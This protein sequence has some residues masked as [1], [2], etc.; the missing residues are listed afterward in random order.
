MRKLFATMGL[1]GLVAAPALARP[2]TPEIEPNDTKPFATNA[3]GLVNGDT[4]SGNTT[5]SSTVTPGATSADYFRLRTAAGAL[6]IYRNRMIITTTGTAGHTGT[7]RGLTQTAGVPNAGTD[8]AVQTSSTVTSPARFNQW[9]S[10]GRE[11]DIYYRVAGTASTTAEYTATLEQTAVAPLIVA[12]SF[13]AGSLTINTVGFTGATQTDTDF[14]VYDSNF[15]AI[16]GYGNDDHFGGTTL[17]STLTRNYAAGTYYLAIS[18]FNIANN[19]GSPADDD[20]RTGAVTDFA[21]VILNSSTTANLNVSFNISDGVNIVTTSATKVGAF[22][23]VFAQFT[24]IPTPGAAALFGLAG[25]AGV[26]RRR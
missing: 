8:S 7:L 15:N 1:L 25:L 26:R 21:D 16:P 2:N 3:F 19:Q 23:V 14:W 13:N 4:L 5:G 24:V 20:F 18:N 11:A 17:G 9:Y 10:F 12:G 22:D 6:G